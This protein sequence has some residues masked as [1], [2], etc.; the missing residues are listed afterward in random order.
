LAAAFTALALTQGAQ[1]DIKKKAP[2]TPLADVE[3]DGRKVG[4]VHI[5]ESGH[6]NITTLSSGHRVSLEMMNC[7]PVSA[8]AVNDKGQ[9]L[10]ASV[11]FENAA[12]RSIIIIVIR[13]GN[14]TLIV[15]VIRQ[16]KA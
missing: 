7:K 3:I 1:A 12:A 10:N 8:K 6:T 15:V 9:T 14:G 11:R 4:T 2:A 5:A 16:R 13:T